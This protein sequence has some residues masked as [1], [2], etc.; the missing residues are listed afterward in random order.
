[1]HGRRNDT[2]T[3]PRTT[4]SYTQSTN[5]RRRRAQCSNHAIDSLE[6]EETTLQPPHVQLL[7]F[8][9][10]I[11]VVIIIIIVIVVIC[12]ATQECQHASPCAR[13]Q[14]HHSPAV[15]RAVMLFTRSK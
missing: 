11:V 9:V 12:A 4:Q 1:L 14:Q 3:A 6:R 5:L 8:V 10:I 15:A 13:H 7:L 2:V